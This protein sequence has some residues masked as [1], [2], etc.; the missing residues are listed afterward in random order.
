VASAEQAELVFVVDV[1]SLTTKGFVG[2]S[3]YGGKKVELEFDDG[4]AGV[5]LPS[6][7]A[8]RLHVR[9]GSRISL[10]TENERN[11]V[12]EVAL[13]GVSKTVRISNP[14]VYYE[15]GKEGGAV[16]RIRK[17]WPV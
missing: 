2:S 16:L 8:A 11:H 5:F 13:S 3:N 12:T 6:E 17:T 15:V 1:S 9:K 10:I 7:M 4:D 14:K